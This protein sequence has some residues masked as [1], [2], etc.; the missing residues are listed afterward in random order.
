MVSVRAIC[1]E[2]DERAREL[3]RPADIQ[4][5][6]VMMAHQEAVFLTLEE[7]A[8][9]RFTAEEEDFLA[10]FRDGHLHGDPETIRGRITDIVDR[11]RPDELMIQVPVYDIDHRTR[12]L[13][14]ITKHVVSPQHPAFDG[15]R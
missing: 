8:R 4:T 6:R 13:E 11:L 14:L 10:T 9:Y 5:V 12:S 15:S 2:T 3:A 1:A 7:A